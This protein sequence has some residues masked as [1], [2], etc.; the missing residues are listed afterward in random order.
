VE[1][2]LLVDVQRIKEGKSFTSTDAG[3]ARNAKLGLTAKLIHGGKKAKYREFHSCTLRYD[4]NGERRTQTSS[5]T[6]R[7]DPRE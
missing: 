3:D 4:N 5:K 7:N 1:L 2:L 6:R